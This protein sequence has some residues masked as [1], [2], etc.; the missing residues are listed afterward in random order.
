MISN[1]IAV[2]YRL[3]RTPLVLIDSTLSERLPETSLPRVTLDRVI[4][5]SDKFAGALLGDQDLAGR[6]AE[7]LERA[8]ALR[9]AAKLEHQA[10]THREEAR[11]KLADG[12][13]EAARKREAA[14]DHI[15][16]SLDEADAAEARGK[17]EAS[18]KA[19]RAAAAK[20]RT[21]D[22]KAANRSTTIEQRKQRADSA[23]EAR[24]KSAQREAKAKLDDARR[25]DQ[26]AA[27]SRA[28]AERLND[29]TEVKK[30]ERKQ[31]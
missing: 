17:R 10:E 1:V 23:A 16:K 6:G 31:G 15:S 22:Q 13:D 14:E 29:L 28:V 3:A 5:S 8:D 2:P 12:R 4:G 30:Q 7:R 26:S 19:R 25:T 20:K 18:A 9:K 21:A 11:E 27:E 24:K